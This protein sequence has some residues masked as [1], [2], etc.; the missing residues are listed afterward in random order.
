MFLYPRS[1][2]RPY[3]FGLFPLETLARDDT[4]VAREAAR[5][6]RSGADVP[7]DR[8]HGVSASPQVR[9]STRSQFL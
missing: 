3:H 1:K 9:P 7:P 5:P 4:V 6:P 2:D 8:H